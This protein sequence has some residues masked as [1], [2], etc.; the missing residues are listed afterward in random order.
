VA[1]DVRAEMRVGSIPTLDSVSKR[2][3]A[4]GFN[5]WSYDYDSERTLD[6][7]SCHVGTSDGCKDRNLGF[8]EPT[9]QEV[10]VSSKSSYYHSLSVAAI[11]E[12]RKTALLVQ[13][14]FGLK[15]ISAIGE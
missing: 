1:C 14:L 13:L 6:T 3:D 2:Y 12:S 10:P 7:N 9:Y 11:A 5:T 15:E 4:L 8:A